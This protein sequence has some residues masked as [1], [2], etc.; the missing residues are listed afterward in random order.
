MGDAPTTAIQELQLNKR[1]N[2]IMSETTKPE[3]RAPQWA[4][5]K[6]YGNPIAI[7]R[8]HHRGPT[9]L[10]WVDW[11]YEPKL[12]IGVTPTDSLSDLV[13][14]D[15]TESWPEIEKIWPRDTWPREVYAGEREGAHDCGPA[16]R[17]LLDAEVTNHLVCR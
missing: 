10:A 13:V 12:V 16:L 3:W 17:A 7:A 9:L 8:D 6:Y 11:L 5:C 14:S 15:S 2:D 1:K 4:E